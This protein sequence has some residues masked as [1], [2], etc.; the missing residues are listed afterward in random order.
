[1]L[2][3]THKN[4]FK[5]NLLEKLHTSKTVGISNMLTVKSFLYDKRF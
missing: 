1:M 5:D 4:S 3:K 2:R